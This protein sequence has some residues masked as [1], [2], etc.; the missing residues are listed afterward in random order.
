MALI[1]AAAVVVTLVLLIIRN[2]T[3]L[4]LVLV[5]LAVFGAAGWIAVTRRGALKVVAVVVLVA[6]LVGGSVALIALGAIDE[7]VAFG[8]AVAVFSFAARHALQADAQA[9]VAGGRPESQPTRSGR[10]SGRAVLL[11]N[12]KSGGGKV[13]RFK[14]VEEAKRRGIEPVL[15]ERR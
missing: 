15:L 6:A 7:L 9:A 13:E 14:L 8:I 5:A 2:V 11:M 3:A 4:V 10:G 1:A 12:P